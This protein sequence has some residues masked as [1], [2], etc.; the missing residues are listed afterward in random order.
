MTTDDLAVA[1]TSLA[2]DVDALADSVQLAVGELRRLRAINAE[3]LQ[4]LELAEQF[5]RPDT[6]RGP[7]VYGWQNTVDCVE[8]TIAKARGR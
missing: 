1:T 3:L 7:F 5:L 2:K 4:A 8:A 6:E